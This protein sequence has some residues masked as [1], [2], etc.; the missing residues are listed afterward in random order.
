MQQHVRSAQALAAGI[1]ALP[2]TRSSAAYTQAAWRFLNNPRVGLQEL[3]G[4]L[5]SA[6]AP[7]IATH[8]ERYALIMH[9]WSR[10]YFGKHT[11]KTDRRQI[12]HETDVG[13]ELQSAVLVSDM[14]GKP[15]APVVHNLMNNKRVYSTMHARPRGCAKH[16]DELSTRMVWLD[17]RGWD[18]PPLH[19]VDREADSVD[20]WGIDLP[21]RFSTEE[22]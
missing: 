6:A 22:N 7:L 18:K 11:R 21:A 17:E 13:Y 4:P 1:G 14:S 15:L 9:D 5:L 19:I 16:L 2:D 20:F 8:C 12:T 10:L 3:A